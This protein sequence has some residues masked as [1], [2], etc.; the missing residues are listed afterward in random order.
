MPNLLVSLIAFLGQ[1][2]AHW[3]QKMHLARLKTGTLR[4]RPSASTIV[5]APAGQ[6]LAQRPQPTHLSTSS[7]WTPRKP[8]GTSTRTSG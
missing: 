7:Q 1:L 2:S 3:P 6:S 4:S 5:M 8:S